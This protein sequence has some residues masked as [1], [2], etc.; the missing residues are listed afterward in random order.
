MDITQVY[1][2]LEKLQEVVNPTPVFIK[3]P[4]TSKLNLEE[5]EEKKKA[6]RK[7]EE[8][9]DRMGITN[10]ASLCPE[11]FEDENSDEVEVETFELCRVDNIK[12]IEQTGDNTTIAYYTGEKC[13]YPIPIEDVL[14]KL[15]KLIVIV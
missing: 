11:C 10:V 14:K 6:L 15:E 12:G 7:C 4:F 13:I 3:L 5:D 8:E 9:A 1:K 2:I